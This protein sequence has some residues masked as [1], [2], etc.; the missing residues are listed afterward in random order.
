MRYA[1]IAI[2]CA[3]AL[4]A[5]TATVALAGEKHPTE[6]TT[7][8]VWGEVEAD[9]SD[10]KDKAIADGL[11]KAVMK[12]VGVYVDATTVGENYQVIKEE[13][14][15][16]ANGFATLDNVETTTVSDG[17]LR[18]KITASV[19]NRPL[20]DKLKAL[21]LTHEWKVGVY[22]PETYVS[23]PK[24]IPDP[25]AETA[26]IQQFLGAGFRVMDES[27]R[28]EL[29]DDD[30]AV[31]AIKGDPAA[32]R[33]IQK[34]YDVDIFVTGEAFAEYVDEADAGGITLYRSR[35]RIEA[36]AYYTDTG[37]LVSM[38]DTFAD[39]LDQTESL[40]AKKCF[41]ELGAQVGEKLADD[42]LIAPAASTPFITVKI[43]NLK[44]MSSASDLQKSVGNLRGVTKVKRQRY[45]A[46]VLEINV[47]L[48]SEYRDDFPEL[49][50][51]CTV[52]KR[53]GLS[54]DFCSKTY[55][56]GRV[57]SI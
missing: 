44:G 39:G 15:L 8:T 57:T 27:K 23:K 13:I 30:V 31:R 32:L 33:N 14:L 4:M 47:Y 5:I 20:A 55:V 34:E 1:I 17:I 54:V 45:T 24:P 42:M 41:K 38:T 11:R 21:G 51:S 53:L 43:S 2:L 49:L 26:I 56:Q 46:G 18:V 50:E 16:K 48:K 6:V 28:R 12:G 22:I 7:V 37:E 35:G 9:A 29:R 3:M 10:A 19:S 36:R 40:S 25:A 52:G